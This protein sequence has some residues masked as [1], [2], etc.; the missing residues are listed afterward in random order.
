MGSI[1]IE[2]PTEPHLKDTSFNVPIASYPRA[3]TEPLPSSAAEIRDITEEIIDKLNSVLE[4]REYTRFASLMGSTSYWRD[5]LGLSDTKFSTLFGAKEILTFIQESG[6]ECNITKFAL[7]KGKEPSVANVDPKGTVKCLQ[8][9]ITFETKHGLGR[10]VIRLL[11]DVENDD[12]WRIYT[13]YTTLYDLKKTPFLTGDTRPESAKPDGVP[14]T[15]NWQ[16]YRAEKKEFR[17]QDPTVLIV[18]AGH[19][20]L[21]IA[22]RLGML[23]VS[24]LVIDKNARTG[25]SWR[26][27]YH[28]LVL[29]DP[30]FMNAMPYLPYPP[31]WPILAPKDKMADFIEATLSYYES[32]LELNLWNST[33][34]THS[35]WDAKQKHWTV[36][37][38][39]FQDGKMTRRTF[40]PRHLIQATGLNGEPRVPETPGMSNFEGRILNSTQ[41]HNASAD[42]R[43]KKVVIVGTGTSGHDI[44]QSCYKYGADVTLVQRSPTFVT[45]LKNVHRI[46]STRY[47]N[48][49]P[50]EESDLLMMSTPMT[51]FVHVGSDAALMLKP[52]DQPMLDGLTKAG[53]LIIDS[54]TEL[55]SILAL[56]IHRAGGFYIDIGCASLITQNKVNVKSGHEIASIKPK[57]VVFTD[58]EELG[59]DE[60]IFCTGYNN[61]RSRTRKVF[62]DSVADKIQPIWGFD[63]MGEI[64]GVW[65]RSGHEAFWIKMVE[66]GLVEL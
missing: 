29:H 37:L 1:A 45:S 19:S 12:E 56:T 11:R 46:V 57:S 30:C 21:M 3:S 26:L 35:S 63:E 47:N 38:E 49:T 58:G 27:R 7:E 66:E 25:D 18:G 64:R 61:G 8:A 54:E 20:G 65:R 52:N 41:F 51:L 17:D 14:E 31:S 62:G 33:Q 16:E 36:E 10:G 60:I 32:S 15:L 39:R 13:L 9:H 2:H 5:H 34:L 24:A 23:G 42:Y 6:E 55:P 48:A 44:T 28:D 40:K 59:A 53:Y 4:T 22:A 43:G 50:A